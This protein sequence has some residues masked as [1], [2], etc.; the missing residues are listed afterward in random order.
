[1]KKKAKQRTKIVY[2]REPSFLE[3]HEQDLGILMGLGIV[4][5]ME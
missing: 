5:L 4:K 1:M 2:V 3:K